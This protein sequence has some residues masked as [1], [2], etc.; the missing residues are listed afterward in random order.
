MAT[1]SKRRI[2]VL[3]IPLALDNTSGNQPLQVH[4]GLRAAILEGRLTAGCRLPS[5]RILAEQLGIGRNAIVVAYEHL[6]SDGL[7][8]TRIGAGTFV[9]PRLPTRTATSP[10]VSSGFAPPPALPFALGNVAR[11]DFLVSRLGT[12]LRHR[13]VK[14]TS[15][16]A[17]YGDPRGLE[18]LRQQIATSLAAGRGIICDPGCVMIVSGTQHGLRI[19]LEALL[20]PDDAVW[21]EDPGYSVAHRVIT[22]ARLRMTPVPV[23][24]EGIDVAAGRRQD[25]GARA[26]YVTPSHQF[27]TGV[28]MSMARRVALLDWARAS[29]AWLLED[30]YDSEFRYGGMP[31][32]ALAGLGGH[33]RV[34]YFGTF[35]KSLF[36]A[37]R[38]AYVVLPPTVLDRVVRARSIYDR[39]PESFISG[40]IADLMAN[41]I[42]ADHTRRMRRRYQ[43][44][45]DT[46]A[47]VL[48]STAGHA[49]KIMVPPQGLHL[50]AYLPEDLPEDAA[51]IIRAA[52]GVETVLLSETRLV[53]AR[54]NGF[55]LG[56][57]GYELSE[58][59]KASEILGRV[60]RA[61]VE[62]DGK[63]FS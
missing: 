40:A 31:L 23:D 35:S 44:A 29:D 49:L 27:P 37:L 3:D 10:A 16:E 58:L 2:K 50:L 8:E 34:I 60:A 25:P 17:G 43:A 61:Y 19:C 14:A 20:Q 59:T 53:P 55:I 45:R 18:A 33:D 9:A 52:A 1:T 30:D 42:L 57:S 13:V 41:G 15:A 32:T 63:V 38:V 54:H 24:G 46:V 5:S 21:V 26:A 6:Q 7:I 51:A 36:P 47:S 48:Q 12:A 28:V 4:A 11:D 22:A 39:F 62:S 56:F